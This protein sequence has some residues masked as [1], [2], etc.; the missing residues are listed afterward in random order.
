MMNFSSAQRLTWLTVDN[1]WD[2]P[3]K[4]GFLPVLGKY[5]KTIIWKKI[6][7]DKVAGD[8]SVC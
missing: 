3:R 1:I 7:Q 5:I 6:N 4:L 8:F 2:D